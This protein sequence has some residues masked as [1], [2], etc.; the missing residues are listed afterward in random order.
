M[1]EEIQEVERLILRQGYGGQ[2]S[3]RKLVELF[4]RIAQKNR[5]LLDAHLIAITPML[6]TLALRC[7]AL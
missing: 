2:P 3:L 7:T 1:T 5:R 6:M 4:E